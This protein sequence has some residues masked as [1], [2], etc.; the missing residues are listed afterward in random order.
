MDL[1]MMWEEA[2][3]AYFKVSPS[4]SLEWPGKYMQNFG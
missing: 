1:G 2:D 3:M 4:I